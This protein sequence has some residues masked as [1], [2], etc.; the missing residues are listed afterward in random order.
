MNSEVIN[1]IKEIKKEYEKEGFIILGI[2]GSCAREEETTEND[3]DILYETTEEFQKKFKGMA[4]FGKIY[5]I[6]ENLGKILG[7]EVDI[8]D[9]EALNP[10]GRKYILPEVIYVA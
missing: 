1:K 3:I 10:I 2:F 8:A 9:K 5:D 7:K 6:K 4:Y